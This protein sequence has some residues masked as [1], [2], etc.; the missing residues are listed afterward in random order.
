VSYQD[1]VEDRGGVTFVLYLA[2][3][4]NH[5]QWMSEHD[6]D[7]GLDSVHC[8][9]CDTYGVRKTWRRVLVEA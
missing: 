5:V 3:E 7:A 1:I 2:D 6:L 4:C 9:M 8:E